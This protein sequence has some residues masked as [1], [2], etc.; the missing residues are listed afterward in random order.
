MDF[1]TARLR[2]FLQ[3]AER[4]T[5][6][7][8]AAALGYTA[9]AVSQQIAK[10]ESQ[11]GAPLF[12]RVGGR[13][14]LSPRGEELLPVARDI[15]D[16]TAQV[17]APSVSSPRRERVVIAG[18]ASA[19]RT[20][21]L[22]ALRS[23][24]ARTIVFDL[25]EAEDEIALRDLRLGDV[26]LA[27]TQEYDGALAPR[28]DRLTYSPLLNDRLRL[29]APPA[30]PASVSLDDLA[31]IGWLVNGAGT[32]CEEATQRVLRDAGITARIAGRIADNQ[33][34][35]ALVVAGHGA[36]IA[37][38]LVIGRGPNNFTVARKDLGVTRTI[39]GVTRAPEAS[40]LAPVLDQ[41]RRSVRASLRVGGG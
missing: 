3:V 35:L 29:I 34:L 28:S 26:D 21:A 37:P 13:L 14:R 12:D 22:P 41:L 5:V 23:R 36:T 39:F 10:L 6:A 17:A 1:D 4:G 38:Q 16:L 27:L 2:A 7:A 24:L 31:E 9:P 19:L 30:H 18:F 20:L 33:T 15:L 8:A 11:L 32:R 25:R 40:R